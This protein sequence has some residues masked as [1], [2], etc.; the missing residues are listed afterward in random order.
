MTQKWPYWLGRSG[1]GTIPQK[2]RL[3]AFP[4]SVLSQIQLVSF[5]RH[6]VSLEFQKL[7]YPCISI[8]QLVN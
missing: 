5:L 7:D 6:Q 2:T 4:T 1:L 8:T 3:D